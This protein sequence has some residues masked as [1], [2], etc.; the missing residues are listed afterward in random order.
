MA[1]PPHTP[2]APDRRPVIGITTYVA[3]ARW[4]PWDMP[5][6]LVPLGYVSAVAAA[7][8]QPVLIPP[9]PPSPA[10]GPDDGGGAPAEV[11]AAVDGLIF[12][13][14]PD[15]DPAHYG[16][17]R[18]EQTVHLAPE[19]DVPEL[20][21]IRAALD[22]G[23]PMLGICRGMQVLNVA[24]GGSLVQHLPAVVGHDGHATAPGRFDLHPVTTAADSRVGDTLGREAVVHSGH[25]QGIGEL[26]GGLVA[27][28]WAPDGAVEA[29]ELAGGEFVVGVL[30]H[31][32][33]GDDHRLFSALVEA[34]RPARAPS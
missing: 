11:L 3:P 19:R 28:A 33:Q 4:G 21:L 13:G 27:T 7:G 29:I 30:W 2:A 20:A 17:D 25:H 24:L 15:L 18:A 32:E 26:G 31:P 8:G 34:S 1:G 5:A 9:S 22:G 12:C 14:G 6:A 10:P 23:V 16:Q